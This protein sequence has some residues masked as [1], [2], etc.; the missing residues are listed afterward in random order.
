MVSLY[1]PTLCAA[2]AACLL[3]KRCATLAF[4]KNQRSTTTS[5]MQLEIHQAFSKLFGEWYHIKNFFSFV[6]YFVIMSDMIQE[7]LKLNGPAFKGTF[8]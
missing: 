5:D 8:I 3:T 4:L 7:L 1:G 6:S 2:Y